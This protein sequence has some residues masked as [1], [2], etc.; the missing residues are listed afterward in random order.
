[1]TSV[2]IELLLSCNRFGNRILG[3]GES[4]DIR[5]AE[6]AVG[7]VRPC[8]AQPTQ[9]ALQ[10]PR[11]ARSTLTVDGDGQEKLQ[12]RSQM[13][14][15]TTTIAEPGPRRNRGNLFSR[16]VRGM[17]SSVR[18]SDARWQPFEF[19]GGGACE[20][21]KIAP[22]TR[23]GAA[24]GRRRLPPQSGITAKKIVRTFGRF[25]LRGVRR[26]LLDLRPGAEP[27]NQRRVLRSL[28]AIAL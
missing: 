21:S 16:I 18:F 9:R 10:E 22:D 14:V 19:G 4:R 3:S 24:T 11:S 25:N 6:V 7:F 2:I 5:T 27:A 12:D 1:M 15:T 13:I 26:D 20:W 23:W 28:V 8:W 17:P